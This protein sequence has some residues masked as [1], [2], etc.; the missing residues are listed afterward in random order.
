MESTSVQTLAEESERLTGQMTPPEGGLPSGGEEDLGAWGTNSKVEVQNSHSRPISPIADRVASIRRRQFSSL[1]KRESYI[2]ESRDLLP[3][4]FPKRRASVQKLADR[5]S[6]FPLPHPPLRPL[7]LKP[8][9][10]QKRLNEN[11]VERLRP[12]RNQE[13]LKLFK[14]NILNEQEARRSPVYIKIV[15]TTTDHS[16]LQ[17]HKMREFLSV[18]TEGV[19]SAIHSPQGSSTKLGARRRLY[20]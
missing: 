7:M 17:I 8:S 10:S 15:S 11:S 4:P 14:A 18:S 12:V 19:R 6:P 9:D 1:R 3:P 16:L 13:T 2:P 5:E 20:S